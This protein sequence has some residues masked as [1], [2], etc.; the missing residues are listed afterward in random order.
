VRQYEFLKHGNHKWVSAFHQELVDPE[1][2]AATQGEVGA[3]DFVLA[4]N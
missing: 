2:E 1:L 3:E 4:K